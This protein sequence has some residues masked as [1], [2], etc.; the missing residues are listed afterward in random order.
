MKYVRC[1]ANT[2]EQQSRNKMVVRVS[3]FISRSPFMVSQYYEPHRGRAK[4]CG[5]RRCEAEYLQARPLRCARDRNAQRTE[6]HSYGAAAAF[7][8]QFHRFVILVNGNADG[9]QR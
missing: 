7:D 1:A 6:M 9:L 5:K 2:G 4:N 8:Q 3:V